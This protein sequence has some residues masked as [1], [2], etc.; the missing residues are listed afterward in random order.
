M[1]PRS[2]LISAGGIKLHTYQWGDDGPAVVLLH[3]NGHAGGVWAPLAERLASDGWTVIAPDLRGHGRSEKPQDGYG[4]TQL[5]DDAV[6]LLAALDLRDAL[7]VG[8]SRGGGVSLL[9]AAAL[10]DRVRGVIAYEPTVPMLFGASAGSSGGGAVRTAAMVQRALARRAVFDSR[11]AA[12]ANFRGRGGFEH[13]RDEYLRAYI[14]HGLIDQADGAVALACPPWVEARL[15]EEGPKG[16][17]WT[18][19]SCPSLP[20]LAIFGEQGGRVNPGHDPAAGLRPLFP[21]CEVQVMEGATHFG[22]MERP[23]RFEQALRAFTGRI[24][25]SREAF[26]ERGRS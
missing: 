25:V 5:R 17:A 13:W 7:L 3:G 4:W 10:P 11:D 8:H 19:I 26:S 9:T 18:G 23:G 21:L 15:Y 1:T 6:A 22:P 20:V 24:G 16:E 12:L 14:D 2:E